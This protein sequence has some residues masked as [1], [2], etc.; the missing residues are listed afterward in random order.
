[1]LTPK[2]LSSIQQ[3]LL[4]RK[5]EIQNELNATDYFDIKRAHETDSVG[6]LSRYDNHPA[7]TATDLYEREKDIALVEHYEKELKDINHALQ[8]IDNGSYGKCETCQKEIPF[9]RLQALPTATHCMEHTPE[10]FESHQRPI[11]ESVLR[12]AFGKFEYDEKDATFFDAEDAWQ[13]VQQY[14]TSETPSDFFDQSMLDY[15]DML[16]EEDEKVGFVEE[17][18]SFVGTDIEGNHIQVFPNATH[19]RY[20]ER[21]D[22]EGVMSDIGNLG[23]TKLES[24]IEEE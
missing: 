11:E 13:E 19:Q 22:S 9:E 4:E 21:L 18:E 23:S 24:F 3:S 10:R 16:V 6:E 20:E 5:E 15:N 17:I 7:D 2:E 1:M 12:P 8:N 14:G